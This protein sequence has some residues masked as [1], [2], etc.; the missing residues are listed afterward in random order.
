MVVGFGM[1]DP[2]DHDFEG[3]SG[4]MKNKT[5]F[6]N[7]MYTLYPGGTVGIEFD[8]MVTDWH[9]RSNRTNYRIQISFMQ[10]F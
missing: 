7:V 3:Q 10:K 9:N 4:R 5:F 8:K 1:D 2:K 6:L